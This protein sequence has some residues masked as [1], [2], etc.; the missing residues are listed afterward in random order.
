MSIA[1]NTV[2]NTIYNET[3]FERTRTF[4]VILVLLLGER[5][6]YLDQGRFDVNSPTKF[7]LFGDIPLQTD[8]IEPYGGLRQ[9]RSNIVK[10]NVLLFDKGL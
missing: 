6:V 3:T 9:Q 7:D 4:L 8:R 2:C 1:I 10:F 5:T